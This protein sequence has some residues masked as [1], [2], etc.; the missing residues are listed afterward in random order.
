MTFWGDLNKYVLC[1]SDF[2]CFFQIWP[3]CLGKKRQTYVRVC[4]Q[5][6]CFQ[7]VLSV[8]GGIAS[9]FLAS[10]YP[11]VCLHVRYDGKTSSLS[12]VWVSHINHSSVYIPFFFLLIFSPSFYPGV[13]FLQPQ[14]A[15]RP[16]WPKCDFYRKHVTNV[17]QDHFLCRFLP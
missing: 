13:I 11:H 4:T 9:C 12:V 7:L 2:L 6:S 5:L 3:W 10:L 16:A 1:G 14:R 17:Q 15:A 8:C